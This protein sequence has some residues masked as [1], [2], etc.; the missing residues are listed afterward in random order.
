MN[1]INTN[2]FESISYKLGTLITI[3]SEY[4]IINI[5]ISDLTINNVL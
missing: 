1:I 5:T 3:K 2:I 4:T